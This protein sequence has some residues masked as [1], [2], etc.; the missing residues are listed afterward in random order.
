MR[1]KTKLISS[2]KLGL[3]FSSNLNRTSFFI[4]LKVMK[5]LSKLS[6]F[7]VGNI[8]QR[9]ILLKSL[10]KQFI[11]SC[12]FL[13]IEF[14]PTISICQRN[15]RIICSSSWVGIT[16]N[17]VNFVGNKMISSKGIRLEKSPLKISYIQL[18][19][20]LGKFSSTELTFQ[21]GFNTFV[22]L[23]LL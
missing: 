20:Y 11:N 7:L 16:P 1:L 23:F 4:D 13:F 3:V 21:P 2:Q 14:S 12:G 18:F 9:G 17:L 6:L 8:F 10:L 22:H 5:D 19:Q 15:I